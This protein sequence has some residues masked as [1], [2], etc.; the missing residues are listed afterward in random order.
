[1]PRYAI[2]VSSRAESAYFAQTLDV[3]RAELSMLPGATTGDVLT[4]GDMHF[5][6]VETATE[7]ERALLRLSFAHGLFAIDEG[8]LRPLDVSPGFQLHPDFVWG[9]KY[10]GKTN[11]TLTQ[12]LINLGVGQVGW[13]DNLRL[14]DPMCGRGTTLLWAMRYGI[15]SVGIEQDADAPQELRRALKKWTKLHKQKHKIKEGWVQKANKKGHG[16]FL[17]FDTSTSLQIIT[18]DTTDAH[19]LTHRKPF[20]LIVTDIPYGVQHMG[21]KGTRNPLDTLRQARNGWI[22]CLARGGAIVIAFNANIPK[23]KDLVSL[24]PSLIEVETQV[25]HRMSEAI[26]RD[27]LVLRSPA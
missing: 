14:L 24:F 12:L 20:D 3:A 9:E 5:L 15:E 26:L 19:D 25:E 10:R 23:R 27:V 13:R 8:A 6:T 11:E 7:N 18:G 21:G 1:M 2:L 4:Y 17:Q 16:K 22:R